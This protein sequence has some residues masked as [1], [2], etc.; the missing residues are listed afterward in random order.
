MNKKKYT[1]IFSINS[2]LP[3]EKTICQLENI[4]KFVLID[5]AVII[6]SST[7]LF[8]QFHSHDYFINSQNIFIAYQ[9]GI[10]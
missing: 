7:H 5:Y 4:K 10:T 2:H 1:I 9:R 8:K 6:N 3:I